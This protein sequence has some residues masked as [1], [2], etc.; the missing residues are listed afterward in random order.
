MSHTAR[1]YATLQNAYD[2]FNDALWH[3]K[4][5][6]CLITLQRQA[7]ARGYFRGDGFVA[8][9][10]GAKTDEIALNP[11]AFAMRTDRDILSTLAHEM[12]H[13]WHHHNGDPGRRGYHNKEWAAEMERVGLMPTDTGMPGGKRVGQRVTHY[14]IEDGPFDL[15]AT[16]FLANHTAIEWASAWGGADE[17]GKGKGKGKKSKAAKASAKS[18]TKF[19]CPACGQNAWAKPGAMIAC[20]NVIEHDDGQAVIMVA[21]DAEGGDSDDDGDD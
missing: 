16:L 19:T 4:L 18:K 12:V 1:Q 10:G 6:P 9:K 20:A 21:E 8:R 11:D 17:N 3:G 15:A 7:H 14:I 13:L 5:P 2:H